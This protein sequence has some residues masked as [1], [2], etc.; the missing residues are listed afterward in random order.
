MMRDPVEPDLDPEETY[1]EKDEPTEAED[2]DEVGMSSGPVPPL[3]GS[4]M[5]TPGVVPASAR[6]SGPGWAP[7]GTSPSIYRTSTGLPPTVTTSPAPMTMKK[8]STTGGYSIAV[9]PEDEPKKKRRIVKLPPKFTEKIL[10]AF[11]DEENPDEE[12]NVIWAA[13][14]EPDT[15]EMTRDEFGTY[16]NI[17]LSLEDVYGNE[18]DPS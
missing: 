10:L 9:D 13:N 3:S 17:R 7:S 11:I 15:I 8:T 6:T 2:P 5:P 12:T 14:L 18:S 16:L 1:L 4:A